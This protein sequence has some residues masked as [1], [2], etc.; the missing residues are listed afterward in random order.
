MSDDFVI[1]LHRERILE[2]AAQS[3]LPVISIY[4]DFVDAGGLLA[5]GPSSP[6]T[7]QRAAYFI[8]RILKGTKPI[9]LPVEQPSKFELVINLK[10]AK[11]LRLTIPQSVL[12]QADQVLE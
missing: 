3:R 5:Y 2:L 4:R 6:D 8:D 1:S 12:M 9:D 7:Y 11:A 10:T